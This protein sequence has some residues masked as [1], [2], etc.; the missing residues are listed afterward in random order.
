[1]STLT[2]DNIKTAEGTG[3]TFNENVNVTGTLNVTGNTVQTGL[4]VLR[5]Y[6]ASTDNSFSGS[7]GSFTLQ[8]EHNDEHPNLVIVL[9]PTRADSI[10][11][12]STQGTA[13]VGSNY[14]YWTIG[15]AINASKTGF[16]AGDT[17]VNVVDILGG[18]SGTSTSVSMGR[19]HL[20]SHVNHGAACIYDQPNTT[21]YVR[22]GIHF[23]ENGSSSYYY[24]H[25]GTATLIIDELSA[26][27]TQVSF[28]APLITTE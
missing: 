11:K 16:T 5:T 17:T 6:I 20:N 4:N 19:S 14:M 9:K 28:D 13:Y 27:N 23:Y 26:D 1:M 15:R 22:Y 25:S 21:D 2:V 24:P 12:I 18:G 3:F 7:G 10:F 8:V